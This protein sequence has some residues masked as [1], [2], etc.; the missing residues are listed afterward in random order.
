MPRPYDVFA[1]CNP[2]FDIQAEVPEGFVERLGF[3]KGGMYLIQ[4]DEK[5][6]ALAEMS[7]FIV[8]TEP[9]GSGANTAIGVALLG[10][11]AV[12]TGSVGEDLHG[13]NFGEGLLAKGVKPNLGA[14]PGDTGTCLVLI[15]PDAQRTMLTF[16]GNSLKLN[17]AFVR[18]EDIAASQYIYVTA[19]LWDTDS[20]K[21]AVLYA[22]DQ[23]HAS[24]T[25][26]ALCLSD[27]FCV[28]RHKDDLLR[29]CKDHVDVVIGNATEVVELT[30]TA[31]VLEAARIM[32][33]WTD[34]AAIT[35][36]AEGSILVAEGEHHR[37]PVF[38]VKAVDTT[39]A[40]DMY[41]AGLLHGLTHGLSMPATG[42]LASFVAGRVVAN[43]GPRLATLDRA[44]LYDVVTGVTA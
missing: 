30:G 22:M 27:P 12:Y 11:Q 6:A 20:Q 43:L 23:A 21:E 2:L 3:E 41:A 1:M 40:G 32:S 16:L 10:G 15:T 34:V 8:N 4:E 14:G 17:P 31:D 44:E 18:A 9:G 19:Y 42:R 13:R 28:G 24:G 7:E 35:M 29:L 38:P 37:I 36:D 5:K 33:E 39:G 26:V 25:K